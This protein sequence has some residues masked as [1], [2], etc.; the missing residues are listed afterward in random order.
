MSSDFGQQQFQKQQFKHKPSDTVKPIDHDSVRNSL[1]T[2][3]RG[4]LITG[5]L[6]AVISLTCLVGGIIYSATN[7]VEIQRYWV[8]QLFGEEIKLNASGRGDSKKTK[9]LKERRDSQAQ[10]AFTLV[11]GGVTIGCLALSSVYMLYISAGILLVQL[12]SYRMCKFAC[13]LALIPGIS[14]L[15][16]LGMPFGIIGLRQLNKREVRKAFI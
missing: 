8:Y 16:V 14:P 6:S 4:L 9:E 7:K 13:I 12:R 11:L 2:A 5:V 3:A 10:A 1:K 15:L